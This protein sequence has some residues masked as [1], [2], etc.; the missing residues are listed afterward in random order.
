[1]SRNAMSLKGRIR[2]VAKEKN[3]PAQVVL[4]NFM[5]ERFLVRL[6]RSEYGEKFV[7]KGG[8]LISALVGLDTRSTMDLDAS[9]RNMQLTEDRLKEAVEAICKMREDDEVSFS[10]SSIAPIRNDDEY[11]GFCVKMEAR[12]DT[13]VV[14]L[15]IDVTTGDA[16][17]PEATRRS[18]HGMFD[19]QDAFELWTY[20]VET[21]LAEKVETILRRTVFTTRPR[22][23]YDVFVLSKTQSYD[24]ALLSQ[25]IAATASHR[26]TLES[27]S[28]VDSILKTIES[29]KELEL[30]WEKYRRQFAY[31]R[32]I[33][34]DDTV[35]ALRS[36][37][38][39]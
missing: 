23:Y 18:F 9:I 25:A 35:R 17:T 39:A 8:M 30:Q 3:V 2:N 4:Q 16:I 5:F 13:I 26:G 12:Y 22:D 19:S 20:N 1:M 29:S 10:V 38:G 27:V 21:I 14:P 37:L 31:A 36:V 32:D 28:D 24:P 33:T 11:G 34:F 15:S 7:L 6:S